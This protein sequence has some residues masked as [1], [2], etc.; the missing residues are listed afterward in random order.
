MSFLKLMRLSKPV[1]HQASSMDLAT[2]VI[3]QSTMVTGAAGLPPYV[4]TT[5]QESGR[6][7]RREHIL[8]HNQDDVILRLKGIIELNEVHMIQLVHDGDLIFHFI[9]RRG[10]STQ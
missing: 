4:Y 1:V 9:L 7:S 2:S 8:L 6:G 10:T 3:E 5:L